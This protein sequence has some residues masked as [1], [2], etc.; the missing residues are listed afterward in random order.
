M[1]KWI[2][3]L[4]FGFYSVAFA[5]EINFGTQPDFSAEFTQILSNEPRGEAQE[6]LEMIGRAELEKM[7]ASEPTEEL[8]EILV[9]LGSAKLKRAS[10]SAAKP[11]E[12]GDKTD[13]SL[14]S[15]AIEAEFTKALQTKK[16]KKRPNEMTSQALLNIADTHIAES[17]YGA[18]LDILGDNP[19]GSAQWYEIYGSAALG[20]RQQAK[21]LEAFTNAK[22]LYEEQGKA[23]KVNQMNAMINALTP[24]EK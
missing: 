2:T 18:A 7:L 20:D 1:I 22:K 19:D 12:K 8:K 5:E 21:A 16:P 14:T 10:A 9:A 15:G 4:S 6:I 23:D 3:A 24:R 11:M 13:S 17:D